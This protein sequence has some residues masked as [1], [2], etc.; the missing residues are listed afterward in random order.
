[1]TPRYSAPDREPIDPPPHP[2]Q[3]ERAS[4]L[5][6][7][8]DEDA[9]LVSRAH[10]DHLAPGAYSLDWAES[11]E[12]GL[13][14]ALRNEHDLYIV[15][16]FLGNGPTGIELIERARASGNRSPMIVLTQ[17]PHPALDQRN[18]AAGGTDYLDKSEITGP[19][20]E[21]TLRYALERSRSERRVGASEARY[22]SLFHYNPHL[23]FGLAPD[24]R[25][26]VANPAL[27]RLLGIKEQ[28]LVGT[29][30]N[31][32]V[33]AHDLATATRVLEDTVSVGPRTLELSLQRVDGSEVLIQGNC[34][35]VHMDDELVGVYVF[36][37]DMEAKR[38]SEERIRFQAS[39]LDAVGQAVVATD[40]SGIVQYWNEAA[41][42]LYGWTAEEV[43]DRP[44][45]E[46]FGM[47]G[48]LDVMPGG[49]GSGE[50]RLRRKDG[51][52]FPTYITNSLI[53][54]AAGQVVA[55]VSISTD[56][57]E[58]KDLE[59]QL[60]QSSRLEAVGRLAGGIAHDFNNMLTT[61]LGF[62]QLALD[63]LSGHP[64]V[65]GYIGET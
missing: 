28:D 10:L 44:L 9:F 30:F 38:R 45:F 43:M 35:P 15:D 13:A 29:P 19:L 54:D 34:V 41:T 20:F 27:G 51:S 21:R 60:L 14:A 16:V 7:D 49:T 36:A 24:G 65:V 6:I 11:F 46:F 32:V 57:T 1:M 58:R 63:E 50:L 55:S 61:I 33:A 48:S 62:S 25:L 26:L 5:L 2:H 23:V 12:A 31:E 4:I 53:H 17:Y 22:R 56:L 39:L 40:P 37:E 47:E 64:E 18:L 59:T 3:A 52:E 42:R 8:D